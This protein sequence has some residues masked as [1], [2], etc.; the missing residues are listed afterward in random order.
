MATAIDWFKAISLFIKDNKWLVLLALSGAG[1]F[2]TNIGQYFG[3]QETETELV[4]TQKQITKIAEYYAA[5]H[6]VKVTKICNCDKLWKRH[7]IE[8]H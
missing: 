5:P 2:A 7:K 8:D 6:T 4:E 3:V 1:S